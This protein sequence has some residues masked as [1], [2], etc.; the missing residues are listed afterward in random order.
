MLGS[1]QQKIAV[2]D[3]ERRRHE[4]ANARRHVRF[5]SEPRE[6]LIDPSARRLPRV[7]RR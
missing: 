4:V 5:L 3:D 6:R 2:R 1:G 7:M